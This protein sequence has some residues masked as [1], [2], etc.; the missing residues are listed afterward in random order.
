MF[1]VFFLNRQVTI[2]SVYL[3]NK[4][5]I[6]RPLNQYYAPPF[7]IWVL[8]GALTAVLLTSVLRIKPL[9]IISWNVLAISVILFL[10]QGAGIVTHMLL[11]RSAAVRIAVCVIACFLVISPLSA[12]AVVLLLL[13]GIAE[14]WLPMRK[15]RVEN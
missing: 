5:R 9:E 12:I 1:V 11:K 3:I 7:T 14:T 4:K 10:A 15:V 6:G 13:L 2:S 8:S